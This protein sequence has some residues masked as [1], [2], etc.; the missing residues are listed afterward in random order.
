MTPPTTDGLP[1]RY[2]LIWP[3]AVIFDLDGTLADTVADIA[4]ALN[5]ALDQLGLP[6]HGEDEVRLMVGGG[7]AKL[8]E[9]AL[10]RHGVELDQAAFEDAHARLFAA[11]QARPLVDSE[12]YD[13]AHDVLLHLRQSHIPLG[14]CTNKPQAITDAVVSGLGIDGAFLC[15]QGA[16]AGFPKKPDPAALIY[17]MQKLHAA[18]AETVMVGDSAADVGA[19][20]AAGLKAIVLVNHGYSRLPA[21]E[22]GGDLVIDSLRQLPQSLALLAERV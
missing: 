16:D 3:R 2:P 20:R 15:I 17:V 6:P 8:L 4:V 22:L 18:P 14:I 19:A 13:G 12:L 1:A 10:A 9:R 11:Y 21:S 7:L 5:T